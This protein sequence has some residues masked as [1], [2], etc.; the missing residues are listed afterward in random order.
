MSPRLEA[1]QKSL[2]VQKCPE[3]LTQDTFDFSEG[4]FEVLR[5]TPR[6]DLESGA[7]FWYVFDLRFIRH[8]QTGL[9]IYLL[10]PL[11]RCWSDEL[12]GRARPGERWI[13]DEFDGA[14]AKTD[15]FRESLPRSVRDGLIRYIEDAVLD[16]MAD[17]QDLRFAAAPASS[18]EWI[19]EWSHC[20]VFLPTIE[21]L[22]SGWWGLTSAGHAVSL[23]QFAS[24]LMYFDDENPVFAPWMPAGGG[25]PPA[26][27][28][29]DHPTYDLSWRPEN[30][31]FLRRTLTTRHLEDAVSRAAARLAGGD[32]AEQA[33][34]MA[35]DFAERREIVQAR[36]TQLPDLLATPWTRNSDRKWNV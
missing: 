33:A 1:F 13:S 21:R 7:L 23:L 31:E 9:L 5:Q 22:W 20:G 35:K 28:E 34:S 4:E 6:E 30:I 15:C 16:R 19:A 10:P 36:V 2:P 8:I 26:L 27:W 14:L 17:E 3:R 32:A 18:Y 12:F 29:F 25:G 11:L 24:L